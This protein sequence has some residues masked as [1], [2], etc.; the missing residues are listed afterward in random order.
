ML[1][2]LLLTISPLF[3]SLDP[4]SLSQQLAFYHLYPE[5]DEGQEALSQACH[6]LGV[7]A[8]NE[9]TLPELDITSF[10]SL[11]NSQKLENKQTLSEKQL[12][13]LETITAHL[14]HKKLKG[15][16][17]RSV[18]EIDEVDESEIDV[19]RGLLLHH[20]PYEEIRSYEAILDL[21][22]LQI[23][24]RLPKNPT[25]PE[26][27]AA[28]NHFIFHEMQFRFPPHA[29]HAKDIDEYTFLPSVL[30]SRRGVCLGVSI[31][32]LSLAQRLNLP[33]TI[34]TPPGHIFLQYEGADGE[35]NIE[36]T[37][38][39]I[40]MPSQ[41]YLGINTHCL[42]KRSIREVLGLAFINEAS[43]HWTRGEFE[44]SHKL[45]EKAMHYM[46]DDVRYKTYYAYNHLFIGKV[47]QG[48][49]LLTEVKDLEID[50]T[51]YKDTVTEDFLNGYVDVEGIK[52]LFEPIDETRESILKKKE[53]FLSKLKKYPKF[54]DGLIQLSVCYLQLG[55]GREALEILNK[56]HAL[57]PNNP[58]VEYYLAILC[59]QRFHYAQSWKHLLKCEQII[60]TKHHHPKFL[61]DL[62]THLKLISPLNT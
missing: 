27:I 10:V 34:V 20:M 14:P 43:V 51:V 52:L 5:T 12:T 41:R 8:T 49:K 47:R 37:A 7:P 55:R 15:H 23:Q 58:M 62:K 61:L 44:T 45:Y 9:I 40:D 11:V 25:H 39:G 2:T 17:I 4:T 46:P 38:R 19:M 6:L 30:D 50:D 26:I 31:L 32:Y 35:I 22:A 42:K 36:T 28:M 1:A 53:Q 29:L 54:R 16:H 21:M 48:K 24:A 18:Q 59:M 3:H 33:L 57:D 60:K 13:F 56:A